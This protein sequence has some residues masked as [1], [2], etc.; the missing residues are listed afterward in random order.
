MA[1][2]HGKAASAPKDGRHFHLTSSR[3]PH[4]DLVILVGI[5]AIFALLV[6]FLK[7]PV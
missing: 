4:V 6:M 3:D 1:K 2:K 7:F 5:V